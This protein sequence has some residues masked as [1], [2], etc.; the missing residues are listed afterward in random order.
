MWR[1]SMKRKTSSL[2]FVSC[3]G[4]IVGLLLGSTRPTGKLARAQ[5]TA[6][7]MESKSSKTR[8]ALTNEETKQVRTRIETFYGTMDLPKFIARATK[9]GYVSTGVV[10]FEATDNSELDL[11]TDP[12]N[13]TIDVFHKPYKK[14]SLGKTK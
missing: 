14:T 11:D 7:S 6:S 5:T 2:L 9:A 13:A 1:M 10:D 3:L 4:L 12:C 8:M